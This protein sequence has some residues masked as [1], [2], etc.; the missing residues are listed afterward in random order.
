MSPS[1]SQPAFVHPIEEAFAKI[2]DFYGIE[3]EYEPR[4]FPLEWDSDNNII[5]A[6][7]PDFYLPQQNLYIELTTLR[8][9]LSSHKNRKLRRLQELYPDTHIKLFKRREMHK[10][11]VKFGLEEE[12]R[13]IQGTEAQNNHHSG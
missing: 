13:Q 2:L 12:A 10:L 3:W 4:S 11:M 5:E 8:P 1:K 6:F 7:T 9:K